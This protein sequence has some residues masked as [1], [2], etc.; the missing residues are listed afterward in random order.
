MTNQ[1]S[2]AK[3]LATTTALVFSTVV[4]SSVY[5][6]THMVKCEGVNSC[7]GHGSCKT[8]MNSCKGQNSCKGKGHIEMT[9]KECHDKGGHMMKEHTTN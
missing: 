7:K 3:K 5:A 8:A 6:N 1:K 4:A 9:E 2:L